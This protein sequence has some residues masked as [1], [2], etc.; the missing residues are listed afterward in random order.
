ME[1]NFHKQIKNKANTELLHIFSNSDQY[2]DEYMAIVLKELE[3]RG[4][5]YDNLKLK[6]KHKEVFVLEQA[7]KGE[8]GNP[9]F[10]AIGFIS[11]LL[12]GILGIVA[13]WIYFFS[14]N[15]E[16]DNETYY[17]DSKTRDLG[18]CMMVLGIIVFI[19]SIAYKFI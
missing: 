8:P 9:I 1:F 11:V 14:K 7:K 15:E 17:Y 4:V 5:S 18:M 2:Q 19:I 3:D 16:V 10:I 12:G 13:G 6:K